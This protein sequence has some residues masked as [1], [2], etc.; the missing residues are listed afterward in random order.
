[1]HMKNKKRRSLGVSLLLAAVMMM[2]CFGVQPEA[3][4]SAA[5]KTERVTEADLKVASYSGQPYAVVN[6]NEPFFTESQMTT[7]SFETYSN[8]DAEGRCGEALANI[9]KDLMPTEKRGAIGK[10]K[11]S[12]W[13]TVKYDCV[14][15]KYLYNRCHL[16]GF[17]LTAENANKKNLITGTRYLNVEGML[18]FE[19]M[20]ADY[21]RE[22]G[23]HVLYRVT[24]VFEGD[25]LVASGVQMEAKSVEDHGEGIL[26]NVYCYNV[27]PGIQID[28][29]T[30]KSTYV[31]GETVG[32]RTEEEGK[33]E[34]KPV[35]N[36][37]VLNTNTKKFHLSGCS[38][39][40]Q[41][42][43]NNKET[44]QGSREELIRQGYDPCQRC[45]P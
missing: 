6:D 40:N 32:S 12:G 42:K 28:Y 33:Q 35:E 14:D 10:V 27:Q 41:M 34:Q 11:P 18:P 25:N 2:S 24:P 1:M 3:V 23:N 30:G 9:G 38:S 26:F 19:N 5:S 44:V 7:K 13:Q 37:Y 36:T 45:H 8:L 21:I 43:E 17:Q 22:T 31:G 15:G 16:I 39:V 20:V 29:A 4:V